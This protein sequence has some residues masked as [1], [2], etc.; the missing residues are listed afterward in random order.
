MAEKPINRLSTDFHKTYKAENLST[1][2][3]ETC[4]AEKNFKQTLTNLQGRKPINKH[5]EN[6]QGRKPINRHSKKL[7]YRIIYQQTVTKTPWQKNLS[8][9][10]DK[11]CKPYKTY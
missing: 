5:S 4:K 1:D 8:T 6:R 2:K 10:S 11:T 3:Y 9:D 7:R